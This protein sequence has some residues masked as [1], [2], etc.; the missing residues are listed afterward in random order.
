MTQIPTQS[1]IRKQTTNVGEDVYWGGQKLI[2]CWWKCKLMQ[3]L[4]NQYRSF[5][6]KLIVKLPYI[7]ALLLLGIS[8]EMISHHTIEVPLQTSNKS[9]GTWL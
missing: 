4:K 9:S 2:Q 3:P 5:I 7:L 6:K 1:S 8:E